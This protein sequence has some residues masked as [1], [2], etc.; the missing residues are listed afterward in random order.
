MMKRAAFAA[1][2]AIIVIV[3]FFGYRRFAAHDAV[4]QRYMTFAEEILQRHYDKAAAMSDGLTAADLETRG[5][6]ER[7]GAGPAMLQTLFASRFVV[8]SRSSAPDG[9]VILH[10]TQTV[11][12]NPPG[13]ESAR[14]AMKAMLKQVV[15]LHKRGDEWKV[16]AFENAFDGMETLTSR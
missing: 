3:A 16:T 9:S 5:S 4:E 11:L 8:T 2:V 7:I 12:F 6:Q 14:P 15:T 1:V 13:V 10:A